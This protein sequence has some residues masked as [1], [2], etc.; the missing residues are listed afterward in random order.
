MSDLYRNKIPS[1]PE[2]YEKAFSVFEKHI[3]RLPKSSD[4]IFQKAACTFAQSAISPLR[5]HKMSHID[6]LYIDQTPF[7]K[8]I[9]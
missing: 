9:I 2:G 8:Y 4:A 1:D 3:D 7:L 5:V 6:S